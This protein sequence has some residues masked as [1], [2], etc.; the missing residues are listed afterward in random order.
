MDNNIKVFTDIHAWQQAHKLALCIYKVTKVFPREELFGLT[1]QLRRAA[2][3]VGS[4]IAE[5]FGRRSYK[6]KLQ[7]YYIS[8]GSINEIK[9]Q[10]FISRD[11][12]YLAEL[13]FNEAMEQAEI[14]D[15]VL[16]GFIAGARRGK[17]KD[18]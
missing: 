14:S 1:H 3:S 7:F 17:M 15:K 6:E 5:G 2:I 16:Q 9:S 10:L 12:H 8:K 11:I 18:E 4:N 13:D